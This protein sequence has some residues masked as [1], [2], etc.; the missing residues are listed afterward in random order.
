MGW[1]EGGAKEK[2]S[3]KPRWA[4]I[5]LGFS[6]LLFAWCVTCVMYFGWLVAVGGENIF[7]Y[8]RNYYLWLVG[9]VFAL[10]SMVWFGT[11]VL[12]ILRQVISPSPITPLPSGKNTR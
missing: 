3:E 8:K 7:Y 9:A 1:G 2:P 6:I 10:S 12:K 4:W 5:G 11:K